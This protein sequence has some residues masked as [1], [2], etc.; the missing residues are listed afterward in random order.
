MNKNSNYY[1]CICCTYFVSV[2]ENK[3]KLELLYLYILYLYRIIH[4]PL[5]NG[6][7]AVDVR[8]F[9]QILIHVQNVFGIYTLQSKIGKLVSCVCN[10]LRTMV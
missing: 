4:L 1:I 3:Y 10:L 5:L 7:L 6:R 8:E 2:Q 9:Q